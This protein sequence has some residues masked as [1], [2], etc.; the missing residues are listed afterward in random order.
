MK[1][2]TITFHRS[3]NYGAVLQTYALQ[4]ALKK[5]EYETA[6]LDYSRIINKKSTKK[7][8]K[9]KLRTVIVSSLQAIH[10]KSRKIFKQRFED[11]I[12]DN[13]ILTDRYGTYTELRNNPP[14]SDMYLIGSDQVWNI[15]YSYRAEF[16]AD[17]A[18]E[19]IKVAS[20]AASIGRY[21]YRKEQLEKFELGLKKI[22]PISVREN[23]AKDFLQEKFGRESLVHPDPVF[24]LDKEEWMSI[25]AQ[26]QMKDK[27]ILCYALTRSKLM[28]KAA[29]KLKKETGYKIVSISPTAVSLVPGDRNI[30][31]AGPREFLGYLQNAEY[32]L[33][34]SFHGTA[35]SI[36]FEKKFYNFT[37]DFYS[38][39]ITNILEQM[40]LVD[41]IPRSLDDVKS[42]QIDYAGVT[43][44]KQQ[45]ADGA[46]EYLK[47]LGNLI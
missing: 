27:Y 33:T 44:K 4:K 13:I 41:R 28:Q 6:V 7:N 38:S 19:N 8:L 2:I 36:I 30:Y 23:S 22:N 34:N 17:F 25:A 29:A 26:P 31:N 15:T 18:P 35:F 1:I 39:R 42:G 37:S 43:L 16:F 14:D 32:V 40:S 46:Y 20:Y 10:S 9:Q 12:K 3:L 45:L 5:C 24:L 21:D 47:S 11:F